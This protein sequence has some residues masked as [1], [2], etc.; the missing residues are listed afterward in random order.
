MSDHDY[1]QTINNLSKVFN[2]ER[3][4]WEGSVLAQCGR[5][6]IEFPKLAPKNQVW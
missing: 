6:I 4:M 1:H 3:N 2:E 5:K